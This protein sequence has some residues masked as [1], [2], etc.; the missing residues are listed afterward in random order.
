MPEK[1]AETYH[2]NPFDLTKSGHIRIIPGGSGELVLDRNPE[3]ILLS[4]AGGVRSKKSFR[5]GYSPDRCFSA[6]DLVP[7][8]HVSLG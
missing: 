5:L 3:I 4:R 7:D 6:F 1:D 8:A 2:I